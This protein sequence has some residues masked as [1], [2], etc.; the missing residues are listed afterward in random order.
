[1]CVGDRSLPGGAIQR[2]DGA[3]KERVQTRGD[4]LIPI[5]WVVCCGCFSEMDIRTEEGRASLLATPRQIEV[6]TVSCLA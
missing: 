2:R 6:K 3:I 5:S 4:T 1:M